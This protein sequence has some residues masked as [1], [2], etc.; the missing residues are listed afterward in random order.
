MAEKLTFELVSPERQLLS[1]QVDMV[2]VP[3]SEGD[4]AVMPGHAP[5]MS[6][7]RPGIVEVSGAEDGDH[8]FFIYGGFAEVTPK[9]LTLLAEEAIPM[10]ELDASVLA[11]KIQNCEEDVADAK[12]DETRQKAQERLDHLKQLAEAL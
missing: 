5:V 2:Q 6:T 9:G 10:E 8:R 12:S 3:G 1:A 7:I 11:Q 4:F